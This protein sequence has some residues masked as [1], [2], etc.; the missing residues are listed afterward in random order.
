MG[1][2]TSVLVPSCLMK[3]TLGFGRGVAST[4]AVSHRI[5][6]GLEEASFGPNAGAPNVMNEQ[7]LLRINGA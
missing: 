2:E 1:R 3:R 5:Q 4:P 6:D 7:R